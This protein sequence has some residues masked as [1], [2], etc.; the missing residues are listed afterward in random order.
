MTDKE[1]YLKLEDIEFDLNEDMAY[2]ILFNYITDSW[3]TAT[4]NDYHVE[5]LYKALDVMSEA[6]E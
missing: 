3:L 4:R 2:R 6:S 5:V 1:K